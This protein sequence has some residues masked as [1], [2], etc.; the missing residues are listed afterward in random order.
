MFSK[1]LKKRHTSTT[2]FNY[3]FLF[4]ITGILSLI[5]FIIR[6]SQ[7]PKRI[8]YPCQQIALNNSIL[9]LVYL[10]GAL[11]IKVTH[12]HARN[13]IIKICTQSLYL[14]VL[15]I[16][17]VSIMISLAVNIYS[18]KTEGYDPIGE[19]KGSVVWIHD[20]SATTDI[21]NYQSYWKYSNPDSVSN[22]ISRGVQT[23]SKTNTNATAMAEIFGEQDC[24]NKSVAIKVNFVNDMNSYALVNSP[25]VIIA[26][27]ELLTISEEEIFV[28][29]KEENIYV[30]DI[31]KSFDNSARK[32]FITAIHEKFPKVHVIGGYCYGN[33]CDYG[34]E[35]TEFND[36]KFTF[37]F[38]KPTGDQYCA[39]QSEQYIAPFL[40]KADY[41]INVPLLKGHSAENLG[42]TL[43]FKNHFGTISNPRGA[44]DCISTFGN[45]EGLLGVYMAEFADGRTIA[46]KTVLTIGDGIFS[47]PYSHDSAP[48][49]WDFFKNDTPNSIFMSKDP[50]AIDSLMYDLIMTEF[51]LNKKPYVIPGQKYL[52]ASAREGLGIHEHPSFSED[53]SDKTDP[54]CWKYNQLNLIYCDPDCPKYFS[55]N[56][57]INNKDSSDKN[58]VLIEPI[59]TYCENECT[60]QVL[61]GTE[62][63]ITAEKPNSSTTVS[64]EGVQCEENTCNFTLTES[65]TIACNF[66]PVDNKTE[67]NSNVENSDN[68]SNDNTNFS[69][70]MLAVYITISL[71]LMSTVV[72][73][74]LI[75][76]RETIKK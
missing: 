69:P 6:T 57:K 62:I 22:M 64:W 21:T 7:K 59:N 60:F 58:S 41:I 18:K 67:L 44:H 14:L 16:G 23:I 37:P 35:K 50:V 45:D 56:M 63:T 51:E 31:T 36:S 24:T 53:C 3:E 30:Y 20:E 70:L 8:T 25:E 66:N 40:E 73:I 38:S 72:L 19:S 49:S 75:K 71:G 54:N 65:I 33:T 9:F 68:N 5:W 15:G 13:A 76:N 28:G 17:A 46:D 48:E 12:T 4:I 32:Y 39:T 61:E 27:I 74:F 26:L 2:R 11:G 43:G 10:A 47:T 1:F 42:A 52:E 55:V 29:F 34:A